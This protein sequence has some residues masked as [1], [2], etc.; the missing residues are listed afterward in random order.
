MVC[1]ACYCCCASIF[2]FATFRDE[3][4]TGKPGATALAIALAHAP[5]PSARVVIV[6][7]DGGDENDFASTLHDELKARGFREPDVVQ[8]DPPTVRAKLE[9]LAHSGPP[10]DVIA[11]SPTCHDWPLFASLK[12]SNPALA[13][14]EVRSPEAG[15][16]SAFLS[17]G[18]LSNVADQTA[19]IAIMAIG[20]TMVIITGGI[21][22]SVGSLLALSA[23]IT[24]WLIGNWAARRPGQAR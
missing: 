15:R 21:D 1:W 18:N 23:V 11:A 3:A 9:S 8:G 10:I 4:A 16:H 5:G 7:Q 19:V 24:A 6:A 22:L 17:P 2:T 12:S 20:M 14:L 13:R